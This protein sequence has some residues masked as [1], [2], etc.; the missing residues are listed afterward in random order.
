MKGYRLQGGGATSPM[1]AIACGVIARADWSLVTYP[2]NTRVTMLLHSERSLR[3]TFKAIRT[4]TAILLVVSA[5]YAP[6]QDIQPANPNAS[7]DACRVLK[8]L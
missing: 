7:Q 2:Q 3:M 4:A 6:A 5:A 8:W 1:R